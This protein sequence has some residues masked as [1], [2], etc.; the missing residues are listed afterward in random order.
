M[1]NFSGSPAQ[2]NLISALV[3]DEA[4]FTTQVTQ[5]HRE[6]RQRRLDLAESGSSILPAQL[7][8]DG[9]EAL[10][11]FEQNMFLYD[12]QLPFHGISFVA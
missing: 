1:F 4:H 7:P 8:K 12:G 5:E 2:A 3:S 10:P 6:A 11:Q 9:S